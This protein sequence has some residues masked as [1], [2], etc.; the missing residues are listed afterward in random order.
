MK[1]AIPTRRESRPGSG[2][3]RRWTPAWILGAGLLIAAQ[4]QDVGDGGPPPPAATTGMVLLHDWPRTLVFGFVAPGRLLA[5]ADTSRG[6][7]L[8]DLAAA[9][10][11]PCGWQNP[12]TNSV[13][14]GAL[15]PD[16][17]TLATVH[18]S[19][20][21]GSRIQLWNVERGEAVQRTFTPPEPGFLA[22]SP[23]GRSLFGT[24]LNNS[25]DIAVC[26][27][28]SGESRRRLSFPPP[29]PHLA[30]TGIS[31][32]SSS[33]RHLAA[34]INF[35]GACLVWDVEAERPVIESPEPALYVDISADWSKALMLTL[36]QPSQPGGMRLVG[37]PPRP[38]RPANA[39]PPLPAAAETTLIAGAF[40][41]DCLR[42][43]FAESHGR[44]QLWNIANGEVERILATNAGTILRMAFSPDGRQ[45]MT[46][47]IPQQGGHGEI[48]L[49]AMPSGRPLGRHEILPGVFWD[50]LFDPDSRHLVVSFLPGDERIHAKVWKLPG[51]DA[52]ASG[53]TKDDSIDVRG[54]G[55]RT[56]D[57]VMWDQD[58][59]VYL[60]S[61]INGHPL[62]KDDNGFISR[63]HPDGKVETLRWIDGADEGITLHAPKGMALVGDL[64]WVAD[65][66]VLRKFD[67]WTGRPR[68]EIPIRDTSNLQGVTGWLHGADGGVVAIDSG[69]GRDG[70]NR[71]APHGRPR[72][73]S[74]SLPG[75]KVEMR[76]MAEMAGVFRELRFSGTGESAQA[77]RLF[78]SDEPYGHPTDVV[79]LGAGFG[80]VSRDRDHLYILAGSDRGGMTEVVVLPRGKLRG[81][82]AVAWERMMYRTPSDRRTANSFLVA[83]GEGR[84]VYEIRVGRDAEKTELVS[85]VNSPGALGYDVKRNRVLVPLMDD[86]ALLVRPGPTLE[87]D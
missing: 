85:D 56:P 7:E 15:S 60:V 73:I 44:V 11:P 67:R 49:R 5:Y 16:R 34:R 52:S 66:D 24:G 79:F 58:D 25:G 17:K 70:E 2:S 57:S 36:P 28:A 50:S 21:T 1:P 43:A 40:T 39:L 51:A 27:V 63:V 13:L 45:L 32:P 83:S 23:D 65:V 78:W 76:T 26:D 3:G 35:G 53:S 47:G 74:I 37:L 9:G 20:Q 6:F 46:Y 8:H 31:F 19:G 38:G 29:L 71:G 10:S 75:E 33:D 30:Y 61:N 82:V 18:R 22:F 81:L 4:S 80:L 84:C 64:L 59:D 41:R 48:Q 68:G 86:D 55:F 87:A 62:D 69:L 54:V 14:S 72:F 42:L 77:E 12:D